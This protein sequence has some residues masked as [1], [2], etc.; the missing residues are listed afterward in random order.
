MSQGKADEDRIE[1]EVNENGTTQKNVMTIRRYVPRSEPVLKPSFALNYEYFVK[2]E[3]MDVTCHLNQDT[4]FKS[5]QDS[6]SSGFLFWRHSWS[7]NDLTQAQ[8]E[9]ISCKVNSS[10]IGDDIN[11]Q[12]QM[13]S[14]IVE[15]FS[16]DLAAEAIL[17][18]AKEW[19]VTQADV[20][21]PAP[22][23]GFKMIGTGVLAI[24]GGN[25]YCMVGG[26]V[27]KSIEELFGS[28]TASGN[29]TYHY[30]TDLTRN[31][32][33]DGF[34]VDRASVIVDAEIR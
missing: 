15:S 30:S 14:D 16:K 32:N 33:Y 2:A 22:S 12:R 29:N 11:L 9:G 17:L 20:A 4:F 13:E 5:I 23:Q 10:P 3:P 21:L 27:L 31:F 25:P 19:K 28:Q 24:C 1:F 7:D 8:S 34:T 26:I 6:G 18:R